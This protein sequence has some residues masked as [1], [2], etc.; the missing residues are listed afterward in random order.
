MGSKERISVR[1]P[2]FNVSQF[3]FFVIPLSDFPSKYFFRD[4]LWL[5]RTAPQLIFQSSKCENYCRRV[6]EH[7]W[8]ARLIQHKW[9]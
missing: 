6:Q 4:V 1:Q 5:F 7:I 2:A 9:Q 8:D 3:L